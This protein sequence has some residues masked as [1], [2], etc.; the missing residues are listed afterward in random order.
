MHRPRA[1]A[2]GSFF[3]SLCIVNSGKEAWGALTSGVG[4]DEPVLGM[5]DTAA[6]GSAGWMPDV[7]KCQWPPRPGPARSCMG[8][9]D[10]DTNSNMPPP[11]CWAVDIATGTSAPNSCCSGCQCVT[12]GV[13]SS[14]WCCSNSSGT[15]CD[16]GCC[17]AA[18]LLWRS[19]EPAGTTGRMC[20]CCGEHGGSSAG[21]LCALLSI[22]MRCARSSGEAA[23]RLLLEPCTRFFTLATSRLS[24]LRAASCRRRSRRM[25]QLHRL[26]MTPPHCFFR[27]RQLDVAPHSAH[28]ACSRHG[29]QRQRRYGTV[30]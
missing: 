27:H 20:G 2:S 6:S 4:T 5:P 15:G 24:V 26:Q 29:R 30:R 25:A 13:G 3:F 28:V 22:H 10:P 7:A 11:W 19:C 18:A 1:C 21:T 14:D 23:A 8:C 17:C 12:P 16:S 9:M